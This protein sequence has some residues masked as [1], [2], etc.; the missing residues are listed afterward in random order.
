MRNINQPRLCAETILT[1]KK[2]LS[3]IIEASILNG[4]LKGED[5]L[6]PH[7]P[8]MPTKLLFDFKQL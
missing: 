3:N 7:I 8:I 6:I 5:A 4:K 1:V 2:L